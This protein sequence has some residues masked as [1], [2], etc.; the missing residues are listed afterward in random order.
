MN[1]D[2][3]KRRVNRAINQLFRNDLY[4]LS[5][6][7]A[8]RAVTH[9]LAVYLESEFKGWN[10][11]CEYNR[12]INKSKTLDK[13][14]QDGIQKKRVE[15]GSLVYPDI[16]VHLRGTEINLL[17]IEV[18]KSTNPDANNCH[19]ESKIKAFIRE[20]HYQHG[21]YLKFYCGRSK[22]GNYDEEWFPKTVQGGL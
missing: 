17:I 3:V 13:W 19:D 15:D 6:D 16:I 4:L 5:H 21:L 18:K 7:V 8:E 20:L 1:Q 22:L 2:E 12:D 11:D 9:R 14:M 10:V